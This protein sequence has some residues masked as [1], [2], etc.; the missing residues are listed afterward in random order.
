MLQRADMQFEFG[1]FR[2]IP[3]RR[4]LTVDGRAVAIHGRAFDLLAALVENRD[5]IVARDELLAMVW[6]GTTVS[7]SNIAVQMAA[8][9]RVLA[10]HGGDP[11]AIVNVPGRGYQFVGEVVARTGEPAPDA[12]AN[13]APA[14]DLASTSPAMVEPPLQATRD[15]ARRAQRRWPIVV[16]VAAILV[17]GLA[18]V[19]LRWRSASL[20]EDLRLTVGFRPFEAVGPAPAASLAIAYTNAIR[21]RPRRYGDIRIYEAERIAADRPFHFELSG[22]VQVIGNA[23]QLSYTV[24]DRSGELVARDEL[25]IP[26]TPSPRDLATEASAI[27]MKIAPEIF[28]AEARARARPPRD[29]LDFLIQ[30]KADGPDDATPEQLDAAIADDE[31]ALRRAPTLFPARLYMVFLLN[32]RLPLRA[33][34]DGD[35]DGE[36]ALTLV[37]GLLNEDPEN[38]VAIQDKACTLIDLG[39]PDEAEHVVRH[40]LAIDPADPTLRITMLD[41]YEEAGK[42]ADADAL[43]AR[44]PLLSDS[45]LLSQLSFAEGLDARALH[46]L[47]PFLSNEPVDIQRR[48]MTLLKAASLVRLGRVPEAAAL[49]RET[50]AGLPPKLRRQAGLRRTY[51]ELPPDAWTAFQAALTQAGMPS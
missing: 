8:A 45:P 26:F 33:A 12:A 31:Q 32:N 42:F 15:R 49:V 16:A 22:T 19:V 38:L 11:K 35:A 44:E 14:T 23:A 20:G 7:D 43:V 6:A 1:P 47:D 30:S 18:A 50:I 28:R 3:A 17:L 48:L 39:R 9:R 2:L 40:G 24:V 41:V 51:Y 25:A 5:R 34:Q 29:A 37:D 4:A 46:D 10:A 36:R 27:Q 13:E 21:T